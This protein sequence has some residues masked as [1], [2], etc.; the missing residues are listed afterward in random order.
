VPRRIVSHACVRA[1]EAAA[2]LVQEDH[3]VVRWVEEGRVGFG[4]A[5][6]GAAVQVDDWGSSVSF[7][8]LI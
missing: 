1:R 8:R 2:A 5:P 6:A 3:A 4:G 7:G